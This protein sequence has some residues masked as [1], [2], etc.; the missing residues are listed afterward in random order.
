MYGA[1]VT[2]ILYRV[3]YIAAVNQ[4]GPKVMQTGGVGVS[5]NALVWPEGLIG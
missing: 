3:M 2:N 1:N 4:V 5:G